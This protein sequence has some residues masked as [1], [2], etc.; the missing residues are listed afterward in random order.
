MTTE[1]AEE[2]ASESIFEDTAELT[3]EEKETR[4]LACRVWW[5]VAIVLV[6]VAAVAGIMASKTRGGASG[7]Q[8]PAGPAGIQ[9]P[10][11]PAMSVAKPN[12]ITG[13]E[14][15][16]ATVSDA[17]ITLAHVEEALRA[18]PDQYRGMVERSKQD[19]LEELITRKLL[20]QEARSR[21]LMPADHPAALT[22]PLW[23]S[24]RPFRSCCGRR[25]WTAWM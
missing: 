14:T 4:C 19:L 10:G 15:V 1:N 12:T 5:K 16:L 3:G 13:D 9:P 22:S 24:A 25:C 8:V 11:A 2:R 21:G 6:L 18:L 7:A 17:R 20:L 23:P